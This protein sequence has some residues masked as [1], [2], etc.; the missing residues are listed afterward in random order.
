LLAMRREANRRTHASII[1]WNQ[2]IVATGMRLGDPE[3]PA[4]EPEFR[5]IGS[6]PHRRG[7]DP[8]HISSRR[9]TS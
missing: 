9:G 4:A 7:K 2:R 3:V 8:Q 5:P 1:R 6:A